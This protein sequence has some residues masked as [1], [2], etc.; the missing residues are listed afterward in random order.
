MVVQMLHREHLM[1]DSVTISPLSN[2]GFR[3]EVAERLKDRR[4]AGLARASGAVF[5]CA[6]AAL[7]WIFLENPMGTL[8]GYPQAWRGGPL[9]LGTAF[10]A[11]Y[12]TFLLVARRF[13][14]AAFMV[15]GFAS[16]ILATAVHSYVYSIMDIANERSSFA[17]PH[18]KTKEFIE[19]SRALLSPARLNALAMDLY[20]EG[21]LTSVDFD[22]VSVSYGAKTGQKDE[23]STTMDFSYSPYIHPYSTGARSMLAGYVRMVNSWLANRLCSYDMD[24]ARSCALQLNGLRYLDKAGHIDQ[25]LIEEMAY[26]RMATAGR[27]GAAAQLGQCR[28]ALLWLRDH[29]PDPEFKSFLGEVLKEF[30]KIVEQDTEQRLIPV[31]R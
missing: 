19:K 12:G 13:S 1:T 31:P 24:A 21:Y 14:L 29:E 22:S 16:A 7:F 8:P 20:N 4:R 25:D 26:V 27:Q 18:E 28:D 2:P 11:I 9:I 3:A 6:A 30:D 17:I 15:G 23:V 5:I 10:F